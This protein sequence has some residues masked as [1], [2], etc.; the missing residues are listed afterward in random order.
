MSALS[1][2]LKYP[3]L[4]FDSEASRRAYAQE[5]MEKSQN[6]ELVQLF[7]D[8][9]SSDETVVQQA[10]QKIKNM[11]RIDYPFHS[12]VLDSFPLWPV[13]EAALKEIALKP[14]AHP[15]RQQRAFHACSYLVTHFREEGFQ[16]ATTLAAQ[17]MRSDDE[18]TQIEGLKY[19]TLLLRRYQPELL[20]EEL[21]LAIGIANRIAGSE[22]SWL[23][24]SSFFA[25]LVENGKIEDVAQ[26]KDTIPALCASENSTEVHMGFTISDKI[27]TKRTKLNSIPLSGARSLCASDSEHNRGQGFSLFWRLLSWSPDETIDPLLDALEAESLR[28]NPIIASISRLKELAGHKFSNLMVAS[29]EAIKARAE[30]DAPLLIKILSALAA[31]KNNYIVEEALKL[32]ALVEERTY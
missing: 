23:V 9:E 16:A 28:E 26:L 29:G 2:V 25:S 20:Q 4:Y 30:Q 7:D 31:C 27:T 17:K 12:L 8:L 19:F 15:L 6:L 21:L 3:E 24:A 14:E 11:Q 18:K 32:K 1:N 5:Q 13:D 10:E 22:E